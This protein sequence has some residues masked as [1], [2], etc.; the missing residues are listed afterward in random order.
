MNLASACCWTLARSFLLCLI[1]WPI[2]QLLERWLRAVSDRHGPLAF[3]LL[4]A[5][6]LF[7]ELL[8]GYAYRH[9]ALTSPLLAELLCAGLLLIRMI[10]VGV[11][12]LMASPVSLISGAA[13]HCRRLLLQANLGSMRERYHFYS[14][15]WHGGIRR[16]LPALVLMGLVAFQEFE[17]AALLQTASWTDWFIAA[18]RV[19]LDRGETLR[20]SLWP[21]LMQWPLLWCVVCWAVQAQDVHSTS[22]PT[23]SRT[24]SILE[25]AFAGLYLS[26]AL[27]GGCAVPLSF[28][29]WNLPSGLKMMLRQPM[30]M[31]GLL[32][33][34]FIATVVSLCAGL[35]AWSLTGFVQRSTEERPALRRWWQLWLIP[36]LSG[37]LLLSMGVVALFQQAGLRWLY[38][39]P[40][41]WVL[42]LMIWL[43]PRAVLV[44]L[45]LDTTRSTES[46]YLA[47]MLSRETPQA[48]SG[49]NL[50]QPKSPRNSRQASALLFRLRDQPQ[51]MGMGLLCYWA[52]L[53][54][55]TSYLL[56]PSAMPSGLVRLYN[57]MHFGR[58]SALS[59]EAFLFFG[60]P[61][62]GGLLVVLIRRVLH[63]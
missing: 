46:L 3:S 23:E 24:L 61:V 29:A 42:A 62:L 14:C 11:V 43:L 10:P 45:W 39:T 54:L 2:C 27:I 20:Q 25:Q 60:I 49:A 48:A 30:S 7:P 31:S 58:S 36:G 6:F 51:L 19:G 57:F 38:D 59:V 5:P 52:Y 17:L 18:Q 37:S 35:A 53:D 32:Q 1:A 12:A 44:Q 13:I 34:I 16:E 8:V 26:L 21:M 41:P 56:A 40:A 4:L 33:E 15:L 63:R 47:E 9:R 50:P 55:S 28:L 22:D